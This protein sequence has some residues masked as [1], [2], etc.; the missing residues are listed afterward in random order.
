VSF[1]AWVRSNAEK[2]AI[3]T[4]SVVLGIA[5]AFAVNDWHTQRVHQQQARQVLASI[6]AELVA[7]RDLV[8]QHAEYHRAMA[9]S[10]EALITRTRGAAVPG[11][12]GAIANYSGLHP[13]QVLDN[14][15]QT[16]RSTQA[17]E[18]I[19]YDVAVGLSTTYAYQQRLVDLTRA[20]YA[21][22]YG[23]AFSTG[24][25]GA[26]KSTWLYLGDAVANETEM[27]G[28]YDAQIARLDSILGPARGR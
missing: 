6:R 11:G 17:L 1:V 28:R 16:A 22:S 23:P 18:L 20:F 24:D 15:W 14:A 19:S 25:I 3:E 13:T 4:F 9:D 2:L 21:V 8:R 26:L 7:N 10:A 12:L 27:I 5:L